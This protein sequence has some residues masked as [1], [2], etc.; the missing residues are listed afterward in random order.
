MKLSTLLWMLGASFWA[1][2]LIGSFS[3]EIAAATTFI[4][5]LCSWITGLWGE[6]NE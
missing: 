2:T 5:M 6:G 1:G 4:I 3:Y